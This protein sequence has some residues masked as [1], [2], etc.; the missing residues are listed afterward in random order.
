MSEQIEVIAVEKDPED[1]FLYEMDGPDHYIPWG[2]M[3]IERKD[4]LIAILVDHTGTPADE[5]ES[6]LDNISEI[7]VGFPPERAYFYR[8]GPCSD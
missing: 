6:R 8:G 4:W 1:W 3:A 7:E 2:D 5:I